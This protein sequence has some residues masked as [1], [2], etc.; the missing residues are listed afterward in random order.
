[1]R[2]LVGYRGIRRS[3]G[4]SKS[5]YSNDADSGG[6]K[7]KSMDELGGMKANEFTL[8]SVL[9]ACASVAD[10]KQGKC[11]HGGSVKNG[12]E[13]DIVVGSALIDM[14]TKS[15][16]LQDAQQVFD[17][18]PERNSVSW[19]AMIAGYAQEGCDQEAF[20]LFQMMQEDGVRSTYMTFASVLSACARLG[21][22]EQYHCHTIKTG[23]ERDVSVGNALVTMYAKCGRMDQANEV[24]DKMLIKDI[25]SWNAVIAAYAQNGHGNKSLNLFSRLQQAG[26][27]SNAFT[28]GSVLRACGSVAA[29]EQGKQIHAHII[30]NRFGLDILVGSALVDMYAKCGSIKDSQRVFNELPERN[31]VSWNAMLA[32]YVQYGL[33]I[34]AFQL[35]GKMHQTGLKANAVTFASVLSAFINPEFLQQGRQVH[36]WV[37]KT[38]LLLDVLVGNALLTMYAKCGNTDEASKSFY[39]MPERDVVSW[40]AMIAACV[41]IGHSEEAIK[42]FCKLKMV[43]MKPDHVTFASVLRACASLANLEQGKQIHSQIIKMTSASDMTVENALV[44]MYSKCGTIDDASK[45][46]DAMICRDTISWNA[47]I[48]GYA[49]HGRCLESLHLFE[50]MQSRRIKPNEI[51]FVGVLSACSHAGLVDEGW[52]YYSSMRLDHGMLPGLEHYACMVDLLGRAG[53]LDKAE[54]LMNDMPFGPNAFVCRTLLGACRVHANLEVGK[55]VAERLIELDPQDAATYVTLS[56]IYAAAGR[57]ET[58]TKVRKMMKDR[59]VRKDPGFSWIEVKNRV[60][61]FVVGDQ[62]HPQTEEIYAGLE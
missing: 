36:V 45:L 26:V 7:N 16:S 30:E 38:S 21:D 6:L 4:M 57:W 35:L 54:N 10:I 8:G 24:F 44:T 41:Q 9:R 49:Q 39:E 20:R 15:G 31:V 13:Y 34:E 28:L 33:G 48:T 58:A 18:M 42:L 12:F 19:T 61:A 40:N 14:Y 11:I 23:F 2:R 29:L 50:Q 56:N 47:M 43:G 1:M 37:I 53:Q 5:C 52:H 3:N 51:S 62:T 32:G 22:L 55:R 46:F 60:H 17:E 27:K 25:V 59:G